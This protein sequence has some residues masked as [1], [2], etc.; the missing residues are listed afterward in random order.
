MLMRG[1]QFGLAGP[2]GEGKVNVVTRQ[3]IKRY[4]VKSV[5]S[6]DFAKDEHT[7]YFNAGNILK[8]VFFKCVSFKVRNGIYFSKLTISR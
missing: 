5:L 1:L 2:S 4:K 7:C 6:S 8:V 3:G